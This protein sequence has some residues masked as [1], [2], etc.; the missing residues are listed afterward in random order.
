M[1]SGYGLVIYVRCRTGSLEI[2]EVPTFSTSS[3]RCRT[4]SLE[5][6]FLRCYR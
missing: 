2:L 5:K 3:V 1:L 6:S 4:G